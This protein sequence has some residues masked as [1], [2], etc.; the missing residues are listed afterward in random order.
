MVIVL[1][2]CDGFLLVFALGN[3]NN[4]NQEG[5]LYG[6]CVGYLMGVVLSLIIGIS[7][8]KPDGDEVG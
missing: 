1:G 4:D 5:L 2:I 7:V 3:K 8:V 6:D